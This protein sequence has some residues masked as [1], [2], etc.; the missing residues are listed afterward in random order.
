MHAIQKGWTQSHNRVKGRS[1]AGIGSLPLEG[2]LTHMT[3]SR[4][5]GYGVIKNLQQT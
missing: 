1:P 3:S 5:R 4:A 2:L